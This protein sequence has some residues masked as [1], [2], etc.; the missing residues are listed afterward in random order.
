M[1]EAAPWLNQKKIKVDN[2]NPLN[3]VNI[4]TF[5]GGKYKFYIFVFKKGH[6]L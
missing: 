1:H 5:N 6:L 2:F 4:K 3:I